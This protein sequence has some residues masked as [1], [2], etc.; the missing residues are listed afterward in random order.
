MT[1]I[2]LKWHGTANM[3]LSINETT[4]HFDPW[5]RRNQW[6]E[7]VIETGIESV[8]DDALIFISHGHFDHLQDVPEI[9]M[10]REN[11]KVHCSKKAKHSISKVLSKKEI[12]ERDMENCLNRVI[13]VAPGD[14]LEYPEHDLKVS[15]LKSRHVRFDARSVLRVLFN[16]TAWRHLGMILKNVRGFPKGEVMGYD[17]C[18]EGETRVVMFGSLCVK[19]PEILESHHS[20]DVFIAPVAG[21]FNADEIALDMTRHLKPKLVVPVHHDNFFPP[22]SYWTPLERLEAGVGELD[23]PVE[24]LVPEPGREIIL[25]P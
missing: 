17:V 8:R 3:Q 15:V 18:M 1:E 10:M 24:L 6:A 2:N 19:Y 13:E 11:I 12:P 7:P 5:F 20:P 22:I 4:V 14:I 9:L 23:P 16:G 25:K 21:R